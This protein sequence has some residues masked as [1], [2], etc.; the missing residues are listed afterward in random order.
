MNLSDKHLSVFRAEATKWMQAFG[1]VDWEVVI[2]LTDDFPE[3]RAS[4]LAS[5]L[6]DRCAHLLLTREWDYPPADDELR[7]C[8][9]H[10]VMELLLMNL[11]SAV[12]VRGVDTRLVDQEMHRLIRIF[13]NAIWRPSHP[14][15][16]P[17]RW[18]PRRPAAK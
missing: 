3:N 9:F 7:M 4:C 5:S 1:L 10:E 2:D 8:A 6:E 18:I 11:R 13:E 12:D 15:A 17:K 14:K 16:K